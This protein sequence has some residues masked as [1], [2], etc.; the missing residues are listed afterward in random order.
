VSVSPFPRCTMPIHIAWTSA[1]MVLQKYQELRKY[2]T[3]RRSLCPCPFYN[4]HCDPR[5]P[6][7][8]GSQPSG[9]KEATR[10][11]ETT[12]PKHWETRTPTSLTSQVLFTGGVQ[13]FLLCEEENL[14]SNETCLTTGG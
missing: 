4:Q 12:R 3:F 13:H 7:P 1:S 10:S 9:E 14:P 8:G 11:H 2:Q 5:L 6:D